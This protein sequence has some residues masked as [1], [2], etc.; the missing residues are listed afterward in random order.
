MKRFSGRLTAF[1]KWATWIYALNPQDLLNTQGR[2]I[3]RARDENGEIVQMEMILL[4]TKD[5]E[6]RLRRETQDIWG[7]S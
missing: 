7:N 1:A 5:E 6:Q 2:F 3:Q 4:H